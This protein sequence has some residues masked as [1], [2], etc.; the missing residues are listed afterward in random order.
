MTPAPQP[1]D[2]QARHMLD[3][4]AAAGR[5]ATET[6]S[7]EAA[8]RQ[9]KETRGGSLPPPAPVALLQDQA[10]PGPGG[11]IP[12]RLI[13]P[14]A[15]GEGE[16]LPGILWYH[17]GG[18]VMGDLDT[19]EVICRALANA[20]GAAVIQV[21]YRRPPEAKFPAAVDDSYAALAWVAA[22]GGPLKIDGSRLAVAGDSAGG[23]LAAVVALMARE[24]KGPAL[25]AQG[26]VYPVTDCTASTPSYATRAEG[27][28]L[29]AAG[30]RWFISHYL[31][32]PVE[33]KDW[34]ASP[35]FAA[36]L[37]GLPPAF[38]V[39]AG[40]DVLGDEG[41]AY[42]EALSKAGTPITHRPFP[43][44]IHGFL[45]MGRFVDAAG[46]AI[47]E[48]GEMLGKHLKA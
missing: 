20:A 25:R 23:N 33:A 9:Y 7:A 34:R 36:D 29:T 1:L 17:G 5:P 4:A 15:A 18:W 10:I 27:F 42:A 12:I 40:Y 16:V 45:G 13:R 26:L 44:Q 32:D 21:D 14:A 31:N 47:A 39:T 24:R 37:S 19:H 43:G 38:V 6:L 11:D 46:I 41:R 22:H 8:R 30:M 2:P 3:L 48:M 35:L 28:G